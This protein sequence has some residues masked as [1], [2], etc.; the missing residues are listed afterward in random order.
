M[1]LRVH[2]RYIA[3]LITQEFSRKFTYAAAE[4]SPSG[5]QRVQSH[6][7]A[8]RV[9]ASGYIG[10]P[11]ELGAAEATEMPTCPTESKDR[12]Y[13]SMQQIFNQADDR[14]DHS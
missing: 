1:Y 13:F 12:A 9:V 8:W 6:V 5:T 3:K 7:R 10:F 4:H 11:E 2:L 14:H